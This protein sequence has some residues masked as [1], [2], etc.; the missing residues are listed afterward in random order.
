MNALYGRPRIAIVQAKMAT[1]EIFPN[2]RELENVQFRSGT[3][4]KKSSLGFQQIKDDYSKFPT[5][6]PAINS[7]VLREG[8]WDLAEAKQ[9]SR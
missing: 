5:I 7:D 4:Q 9:R 6:I 3:N 1:V 8:D 2:C